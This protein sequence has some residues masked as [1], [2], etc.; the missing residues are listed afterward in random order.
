[1]IPQKNRNIDLWNK[2][3]QKLTHAPVNTLSST[4]EPRKYNGEKTASSISV[5]GKTGELHVKESK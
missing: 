4:K 1:M 5:S 2:I 3:A